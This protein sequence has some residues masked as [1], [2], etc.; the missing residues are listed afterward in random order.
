MFKG[1]LSLLMSVMVAKFMG[2]QGG[3]ASTVGIP[4]AIMRKIT[5][6]LILFTV[7]SLLFFGGF[8]TILVD[9]ILASYTLGQVT[10]TN[11]S[12]VGAG[13]M[14][15]ATLTYSITFSER[16]W[17]QPPRPEV[18]GSPLLVALANLI[19]GVHQQP[20]DSRTHNAY[21]S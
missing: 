5:L 2:H 1:F 19:N 13:L 9:L 15:L 3:Y 18:H 4:T 10:L 6:M 14:L 7:G 11:L 16:F 21:M 12:W 8:L 17:R 20:S